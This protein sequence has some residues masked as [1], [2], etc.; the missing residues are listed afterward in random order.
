VKK[1]NTYLIASYLLLLG[2]LNGFKGTTQDALP[3]RFEK[4]LTGQF[5]E[6]DFPVSCKDSIHFLMEMDTL[7]RAFHQAGYLM[8]GMSGF[9]LENNTFRVYYDPGR[10]FNWLRF[11]PGNVSPALMESLGFNPGFWNGQPVFYSQLAKLMQA[12]LDHYANRGHP[13]ATVRLDSLIIGAD[14]VTGTLNLVKNKV[15]Y[16]DSINIVSTVAISP[17]FLKRHL[18]IRD[19]QLYDQSKVDAI[20]ER[21]RALNFIRLDQSPTVRFQ[22]NRA[23]LNLYLLPYQ[24]SRFDILIGILPDETAT[25]RIRITGDVT[26][27]LYNKLGQGE[28]AGFR[29][30]SIASGIQEL[31]LQMNYPYLLNL[32]FGINGAFK[33]YSNTS[34]NRDIDLNLGIQYQLAADQD[35]KIYWHNTSSRLLAIDTA[36]ILSQ[37]RLPPNLDIRVNGIG[38]AFDYQKLNYR[39]NPRSGF[40][41]Q[42]DGTAGLKE[43]LPNQEIKSLKTEFIDFS[44]SY[45]T[46]ENGYQF[47]LRGMFEYYLPFGRVFALKAA[48][49]S[50]I[51]LSHQQLF[52]NEAF[53]IG[54]TGTLRGFDEESLYSNR[55]SVFTL[56]ARLLISTNSYLFVFG[57]YGLVSVRLDDSE[58][59][60]RPLG[61]GAGLSLDTGSG[62][63]Q[64]SAAAGS[65]MGL[66][67]DFGRSKVHVGYVNIF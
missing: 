57:D 63:L 3:I 54:G 26:A 36:R 55:Y 34:L 35:L 67:L 60:D 20:P 66:G 16:F 62:I 41:L 13:F 45:D 42:L 40:R 24:N 43:V 18:E 15:F 58:I 22:G 52:R 46:I 5:S 4:E 47:S 23:I 56:E 49:Q 53:R 33:L 11:S 65:Q 44:S 10:Q 61:I 6:F 7:N 29:Y 32:P 21:I 38:L 51:K 8:A 64:I 50:G 27:D 2:F 1:T 48:N 14:G 31:S 39:F 9:S 17:A 19:G 25:S 30:K 28:Y 59:F 37:K 12:L